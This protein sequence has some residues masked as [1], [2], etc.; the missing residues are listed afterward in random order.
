M[1]QLLQK[2]IGLYLA[3]LCLICFN[4]SAKQSL[5]Y[6]FEHISIQDG[7]PTSEIN[8][9]Y[10]DSDG[11]IWFATRSG[12]SQYDGYSIRTFKSNLYTP[13]L[14]NN[15]VI[16]CM[17]EDSNKCLWIGTSNGLNIL[18]KRTGEIQKVTHEILNESLIVKILFTKE[19]YKL[20]AT[21]RGVVQYFPESNNCIPFLPD[22][23]VEASIKS[24]IQD[25]KG[26][27]W[28]GTWSDGLYRYNPSEDQI[29]AYPPLSK[30]N[31][32]YTIYED[33]QGRIWVGTWDDGLRR[34]ENPYNME[35]LRITSYKYEAQN[36]DGLIDKYVYDISEDLNTGMIWVGTRK[37]LSILYDE[38]NG[39]FKNYVPDNS[40]NSISYNVVQSILRDNRGMM[41]IATL[42]GGVNLVR[43]HKPDFDMNRLDD[44]S[45]EFIHNPSVRSILVDKNGLVWIGLGN[46]GFLIYNRL[47]GRYIHNTDSEDFGFIGRIP[48][49]NTIVQ[50]P[51]TG[52]IWIGT[53]DWGI[54]EYDETAPRGKRG[55][56]YNRDSVSWMRN[57]CVFSILEDSKG[58]TWFGTR[59]GIML[60]TPSY[61][62]INLD[63]C[64]V[65]S[66][67]LS[68]LSIVAMTEDAEGNIWAG[69]SNGGVIRISGDPLV[70]DGLTFHKYTPTE[71]T[72]N[73]VN[74]S[75]LFI[76]S[77]QRLWAGTEGGGLSLYDPAKDCFRPL[78]HQLSLP[79][80][81]IVSI[82]Q[83]AKGNLWMG[84][85]V[86]L[87]RLHIPDTIADATYRLYTIS[88]GLQDN[89]FNR[90]SSFTDI[91]GEMFF[92]GHHGYNSFFPDRMVDDVSFPPVVITDIKI[93]N[94]SWDQLEVKSKE[95]ISL[96]AP[97]FTDKIRL[98]Y[99]QNNFDIE[100][101][102]L[103]YT[104]PSQIKYAYRL[105]GFN[106]D[107]QYTDANRRF[108]YYNNLDAGDYIFELKASNTNGVWNE[109]NIKTIKVQILPPPWRT[110]WAYLLYF[111]F[112]LPS[113]EFLTAISPFLKGFRERLFD[114]TYTSD[115]QVGNL[116]PEWAERLGLT[117]EVA[118]GVGAFDCHMGAVGAEIGPKTFVRVIGTSTCDIMVVPYKEMEH[119]L[120]PGICG[121]V[122]GSVIPGMIGLEAGQSGFG[123]I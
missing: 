8:Q 102:A 19:G 99:K 31:S 103:G 61:K 18:N 41:W 89:E 123:D 109:N 97:G 122:D 87:I 22:R 37:G 12:L 78:H 21:E 65:G 33:K 85:N 88:D 20:I 24:L 81:A 119:K 23:L 101:A 45:H 36:T 76:D 39:N 62:G 52:K 82:Q 117:T 50:S 42:G 5:F 72:I 63:H 43:T 68:Y 46:Q 98:S 44:F 110:S 95:N 107:W 49:I 32:A 48:T 16:Y 55:K 111:L 25:S 113:E 30:E 121:Q 114:D 47:T 28:V 35:D 13:D 93:Y 94:Q 6:E 80:D 91:N 3:I 69:A 34:I 56:H 14:L 2:K 1:Q 15:N 29:Y 118:V 59:N 100:F 26:N 92:G 112:I 115:T 10:Q 83:D 53:Y 60:L 84:S 54:V 79:G 77:K 73:N 120:I 116:T 9:I 75:T 7:L 104:N 96:M 51:T 17:A 57:Q 90:N 86:G 74:V 66:T 71:G 67:L 58:N 4:V 106:T 108:A 27:I 40:I 64:R 38:A 70:E 105:K 11:F